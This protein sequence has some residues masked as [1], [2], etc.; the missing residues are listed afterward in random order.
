M[1]AISLISY[2]LLSIEDGCLI[3]KDNTCIMSSFSSSLHYWSTRTHKPISG[4]YSISKNLLFSK[5]K[6]CGYSLCLA[7]YPCIP[8]SISTASL[9]RT[10]CLP[11][12]LW[13]FGLWCRMAFDWSFHLRW[14]RFIGWSWSCSCFWRE[15]EA[16]LPGFSWPESW[17]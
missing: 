5:S 12:N 7:L 9:W 4:S 17:L 11:G 15:S 16:F 6:S 10:G 14:P 8:Y 3:F 1:R 13:S 2:I